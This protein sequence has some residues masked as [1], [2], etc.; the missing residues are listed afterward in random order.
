MSKEPQKPQKPQG[1]GT[2]EA[3][4]A[5]TI[6]QQPREVKIAGRRYQIAPPT[7]ATLFLVSKQISYLPPINQDTKN[8]LAEILGKAKDCRPVTRI[9]AIL[10][11]GAKR[12]N[13]K[14]EVEVTRRELTGQEPPKGLRRLFHRRKEQ[15]VTERR[16]TMLEIDWLSAQIAENMTIQELSKLVITELGGLGIG[17]FFGL[18]A[19]LS[20]GNLLRPKATETPQAPGA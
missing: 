8:V 16:R 7:P 17:D 13:E 5:D 9:A 20:A 15:H 12:I 11:L 2:I 6:L 3:A 1:K 4:A 18:T 14:R 10:V 19:S